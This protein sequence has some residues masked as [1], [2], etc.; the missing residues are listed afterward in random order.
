MIAT[1]LICIS[2]LLAPVAHAAENRPPCPLQATE[3]ILEAITTWEQGDSLDFLSEEEELQAYLA[4]F[5]GVMEQLAQR[6][7]YQVHAGMVDGRTA[8]VDVT[9]TA[10]NAGEMAGPLLTQAATYLAF[11]RLMGREPDLNAHLA[12][13]AA[14]LIEGM[15]TISTPTSVHL[16]MGGDGEWKLD[17]S[18]EE[19]LMFLDALCGGGILPHINAIEALMNHMGTPAN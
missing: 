12:A 14:V 17:L 10:V 16:I 4:T 9:I 6:M 1:Y 5:G 13:R 8:V 18:N 7:S 15:Y 2:I 19:N 3:E 11:Q